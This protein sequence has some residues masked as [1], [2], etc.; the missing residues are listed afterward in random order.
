MDELVMKTFQGLHDT[1][2]TVL[3]LIKS[4][5][6]MALA[7]GLQHEDDDEDR[8]D[9]EEEKLREE[10]LNEVKKLRKKHEELLGP[11]AII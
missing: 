8:D 10:L 7:S 11:I 4:D 5:I 9:E 1:V 2:E 3:T 6:N